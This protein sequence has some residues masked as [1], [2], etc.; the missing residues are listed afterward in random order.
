MSV[1]DSGK[2]IAHLLRPDRHDQ[3]P[4]RRIVETVIL[5]E[6]LQEFLRNL[7]SPFA[8]GCRDSCI[9]VL[10]LPKNLASAECTP[11]HEKFG[12]SGRIRRF[13]P[14]YFSGL[15]HVLPG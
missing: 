12:S 4:Q 14:L 13:L 11:E 8:R 1:I 9:K 2:L 3:Q 15:K 5:F 10:I 7:F 6:K